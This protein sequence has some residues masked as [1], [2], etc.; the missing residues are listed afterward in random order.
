[1][2]L[3]REEI[4]LP[5]SRR[6]ERFLL[7]KFKEKY[8]KCSR[9]KGQQGSRKKKKKE[10]LE[11]IFRKVDIIFPRSLIDAV[12]GDGLEGF[13]GDPEPDVAVAFVPPKFFL[14]EVHLLHFMVPGVGEGHG[15]GFGIPALPRQI[16]TSKFHLHHRPRRSSDRLQNCL[17]FRRNNVPGGAGLRT[18]RWQC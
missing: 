4:Y 16:T 14:L 8:R 6:N 9:R 17:P 1:M 18:R 15:P 11:G 13:R 5:G 12:L 2:K 7:G 3:R 10:C